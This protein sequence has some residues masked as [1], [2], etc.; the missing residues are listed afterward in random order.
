MFFIQSTLLYKFYEILEYEGKLKSLNSDIMPKTEEHESMLHRQSPQKLKGGSPLK[1]LD[2]QKDVKIADSS[3]LSEDSFHLENMPKASDVMAQASGSSEKELE[4]TKISTDASF[5]GNKGIDS[6]SNI[7]LED[8]TFSIRERKQNA[9]SDHKE[10]LII[11]PEERHLK[12][13]PKFRFHFISSLSKVALLLGGYFLVFLA[14]NK[15]WFAE[16]TASISVSCEALLPMIQFWA[17]FQK[18]SVHSLS[19]SMILCWFVGDVVKFYFLVRNNQPLQFILSTVTIVT[20]DLLILVQ[21]KI[22]AK[23][24]NLKN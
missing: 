5:S 9:V 6:S 19:Y 15:L 18:K 8:Q 4:K 11:K 7:V 20:F 13:I 24:S 1:E 21:F 12:Y 17:N 23:N 10:H 16:I 3:F 2:M 22:Y 14:I